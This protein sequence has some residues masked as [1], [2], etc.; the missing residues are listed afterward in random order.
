MYVLSPGDL[1]ADGVSHHPVKVGNAVPRQVVE[2]A[3]QELSQQGDG[4]LGV[5]LHLGV[6]LSELCVC[7]K[8]CVLKSV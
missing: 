7:L 4:R 3:P 5:L 8:V 6:H 1:P 2:L